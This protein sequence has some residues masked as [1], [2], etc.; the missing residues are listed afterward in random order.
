M[1]YQNIY[2]NFFTMKDQFKNIN[3]LWDYLLYLLYLLYIF[4]CFCV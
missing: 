3:F 1:I 4:E 2:N